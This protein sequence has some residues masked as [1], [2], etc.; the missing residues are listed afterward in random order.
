MRTR[1]I[2]PQRLRDQRG[3]TL[4][5][6]MIALVVLSLGLLAL[7]QLMPA[8]SRSMIS[9]QRLTGASYYSQQKIEYLRTLPFQDANLDPGR[10]PAAGFD[11]LGGSG[12]LL[13]SY[14]VDVLPA[15]LDN[16][17]RVVV[18]VG[19]TWHGSR[20]VADTVYIHL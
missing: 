19:W 2:A 3:F 17:K 12:Q 14:N 6:L 16:V 4:I 20:S 13:R 18:N 1:R 15:P 11:T 10:H 7:G 5:E 9:S 8:G